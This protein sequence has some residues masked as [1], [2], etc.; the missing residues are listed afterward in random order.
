MKIA[1]VTTDC[2][3]LSMTVLFAYTGGVAV[4]II[5]ATKFERHYL[6]IGKH[7]HQSFCK[8]L[9]CIKKFW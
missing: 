9:R 7:K 3:K 4:N 1:L 5:I 8:G 2:A 6:L